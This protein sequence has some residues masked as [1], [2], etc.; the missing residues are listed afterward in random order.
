MTT[1]D[2]ERPARDAAS[3]VLLRD[4]SAG[5]EVLLLR[6]HADT[7]VLGGVYVFPGGKLDPADCSPDALAALDLE[8]EALLARLDEPGLSPEQAA[9]LHIAALRESFEEAGLL[10][11]EGAD[12]QARQALADRQAAGEALADAMAALGLRWQASAILPWS[13]W[14]TPDHPASGARFDTRFF[15]ARLPQGQ[16]ARHDGFETTEAVWLAPRQALELHAE[17]QLE[18]VPPQLLSLVQLC[19]HADV[20]S[21]WNE[22]L[23]TRPPRIQPEGCEIDGERLLCLPG[24]PQHSVRERAL[25]G[26]TRLRW[27]QRRF[28]PV[29]GCAA[30]FD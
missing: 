19:R 21:A 12:A 11:A 9:G 28:E 2:T 3:L 6:R 22:A 17:R 1:H 30:W 10:L 26:P 20:A 25:P 4:G 13:R 15:L 24:D 29:G 8:A 7:R 5:L 23:A 18:L 27:L 16:Q 14:V